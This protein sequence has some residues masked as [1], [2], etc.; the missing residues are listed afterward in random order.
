MIGVC[1]DDA[2]T[3]LF[4]RSLRETLDRAGGAHRHEC[5]RFDRAMRSCQPAAARTRRIG[6]QNLER[7]HNFSSVSRE[8][9]GK[10]REES[11]KSERH[12]K[13][14]PHGLAQR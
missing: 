12:A 10:H 2:R 7:K 1:E 6:L 9:P 13:N 8:N 3:E 11:N 5:R 14:N 4:E